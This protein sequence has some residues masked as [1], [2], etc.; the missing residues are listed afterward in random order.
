MVF[1]FFFLKEDGGQ[2]GKVKHLTS[3]VKDRGL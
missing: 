2:K 1:C 3:M